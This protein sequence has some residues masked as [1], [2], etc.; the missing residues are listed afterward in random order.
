ML[1]ISKNGIRDFPP[2]LLANLTELA[3]LNLSH[4][5]MTAILPGHF[6]PAEEAGNS[7]LDE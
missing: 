3:Y 7:R 4:N 1:N 5:A 2:T 6:D